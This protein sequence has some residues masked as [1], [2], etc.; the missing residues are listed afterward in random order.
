MRD[1]DSPRYQLIAP[2]PRQIQFA[3]EQIPLRIQHLQIAVQPTLIPQGR[4]PVSSCQ[5][6]HQ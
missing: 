3:L 6:L 4:Q 1:T 2:Q 5:R